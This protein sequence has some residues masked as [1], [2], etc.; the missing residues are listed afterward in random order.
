MLTA[1]YSKGCDSKQMF[2]NLKISQAD[3]F[4]TCRN[5]YDVIHFDVQWFMEPAGYDQKNK[6]AF[7]P[8]EEIR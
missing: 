2:Q 8:N 5:K 3:T 1:Y 4:E 6:Q 7:I